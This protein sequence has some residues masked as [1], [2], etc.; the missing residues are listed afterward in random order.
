ML[1]EV[2]AEEELVAEEEEVE[3]MIIVTTKMIHNMKRSYS[4]IVLV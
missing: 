1:L 3:V 4:R 2:E